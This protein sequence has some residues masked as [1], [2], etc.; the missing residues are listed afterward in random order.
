MP[1]APRVG[2][3]YMPLLDEM[4]VPT[5]LINN[6]HPGEFVHSVMIDGEWVLRNRVH[7][8]LDEAAVTGYAKSVAGDCS[9]TLV[10]GDVKTCTITNDPVEAA[11]S[12]DVIYTD[13]WANMGQ[14]A[15]KEERARIFR[16]YQVNTELF[17]LAKPDAIFPSTR[18]SGPNTTCSPC[19][20]HRISP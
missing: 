9:G 18:R 10:P 8:R 3:L 4:R 13:T 5:V 14:E 7:L 2:A 12:A 19:V 20:G 6:Q 11:H 15:E 16:P 17:R 1:A